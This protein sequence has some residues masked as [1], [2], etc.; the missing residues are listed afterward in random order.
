MAKDMPT[1]PLTFA[2]SLSPFR[3]LYQFMGE[4][5]LI[6]YWTGQWPLSS[7]HECASTS[8]HRE[9]LAPIKLGQIFMHFYLI[10]G[11]ESSVEL[12]PSTSI[13]RIDT[14]KVIP[15]TDY[16]LKGWS[17][18]PFLGAKLLYACVCPSVTHSTLTFVL[19]TLYHAKETFL[20]IVLERSIDKNIL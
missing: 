7:S 11:I 20:S 9:N 18:Q 14:A 19:F 2:I 1:M 4:G 13:T 10:K 17:D 5:H 16:I 6:Q 8:R 12:R 15:L 3:L